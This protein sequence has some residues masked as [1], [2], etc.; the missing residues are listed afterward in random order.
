[1]FIF[2]AVAAKPQAKGK[3]MQVGPSGSIYDGPTSPDGYYSCGL[4]NLCQCALCISPKPVVYQPV[5][6][7]EVKQTQPTR[8]QTLHRRP[9]LSSHAR[10]SI[11]KRFSTAKAQQYTG[12]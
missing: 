10:P 9:T 5:P 4:G 7:T 3:N 6:T 1:M 12:N 11:Y 2:Q 8:R